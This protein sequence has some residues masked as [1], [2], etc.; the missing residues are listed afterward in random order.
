M[1]TLDWPLLSWVHHK[2]ITWYGIYSSPHKCL[3]MLCNPLFTWFSHDH[4]NAANVGNA[5]D[6]L[7]LHSVTPGDARISFVVRLVHKSVRISKES[8]LGSVK[9][10]PACERLAR[11]ILPAMNGKASISAED[12]AWSEM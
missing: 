1:R 3:N 11:V 6:N 7:R 12:V 5:F 8:V 9:R 10:S 2:V 4:S